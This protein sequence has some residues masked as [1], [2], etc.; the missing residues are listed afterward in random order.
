MHK[1]FNYSIHSGKK[2]RQYKSNLYCDD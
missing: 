2:Q 1:T